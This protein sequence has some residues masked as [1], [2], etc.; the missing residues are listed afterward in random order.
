MSPAGTRPPVRGD[1]VLPWAA[2]NG[3]YHA[4]DSPPHPPEKRAGVYE[5]LSRSQRLGWPLPMFAVVPDVP[6]HGP[7]SLVVSLRH[8]PV[9]R[10]LFPGVPLAVAVQDGMDA[11]E[12]RRETLAFDWLFVAGSTD[13]K[14]ATGAEWAR[15]GQRHGKRV[16]IARVNSKT[17]LRLCVDWGADSADGTG[18]WRGPNTRRAILSALNE[19]L[20]PKVAGRVL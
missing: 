12:L 5:V 2:D 19:T 6:Y 9:M 1:D 8:L 3:L 16:H 15:F 14:L 20:L 18:M 4:P 10:E 7:E 17:R 11:D 13:W